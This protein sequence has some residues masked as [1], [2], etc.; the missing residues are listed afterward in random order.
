MPVDAT[1]CV[2]L[3][4]VFAMFVGVVFVSVVV[5]H[6]CTVPM[7]PFSFKMAFCPVQ[8]VLVLDT[9]VPA[10]RSITVTVRGLL[11]VVHPFLTITALNDVVLVRLAVV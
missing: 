6:L 9:I 4:V 8:T 1:W 11:T 3:V 5:C 10:F 7:S 2:K